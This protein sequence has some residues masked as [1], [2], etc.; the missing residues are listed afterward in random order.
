MT[1]LFDLNMS[2]R[3]ALRLRDLF[4]GAAHARALG[5]PTM[6]D[7]QIAKAALGA[8]QAVVSHDEHFRALADELGMKFVHV[9]NGNLSVA[10]A[11][12]LIRNNYPLIR[13]F[14]DDPTQTYLPLGVGGS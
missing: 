9:T 4:P 3:L 14:L 12:S 8:G 1:L 13:S 2:Y 6:P 5:D 7:R 10:E 11:E